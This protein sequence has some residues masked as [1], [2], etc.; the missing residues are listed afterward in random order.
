MARRRKSVTVRRVSK[1]TLTAI[2]AI[3]R[4][5]PRKS[6]RGSFVFISSAGKRLPRNTRR[7]VIAA[8]V[9]KTG[10]VKPIR[11]KPRSPLKLLRPG[12]YDLVRSGHKG[13]IEKHLRG[14]RSHT[15]APVQVRQSAK[16]RRI[17]VNYTRFTKRLSKDLRQFATSFRSKGQILIEFSVTVRLPDGQLETFDN[18][19]IPI[20]FAQSELQSLSPSQYEKFV[21][22]AVYAQLAQFLKAHGIVSS[23]SAAHIRS[24]KANRGQPRN[25]WVDK[26]GQPWEKAGMDQAKIVRLE[27]RLT[28][29]GR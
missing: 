16:E 19:H 10:K 1:A 12:N 17:G 5:R 14:R 23:G 29:I 25:A 18:Q 13:A 2:K 28:R 4:F 24:L 9:S 20:Q 6:D 27:Y 7:K 26:Q 22:L 8:Y 21:R 3:T 11:E 15:S